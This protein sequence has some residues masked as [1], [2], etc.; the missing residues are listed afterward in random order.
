[1]QVV[2]NLPDA[3]ITED[4]IRAAKWEDGSLFDMILRGAMRDAIIL[5]KGHGAIKDFDKI[6]W[7][8]CIT[9]FDCPFRHIDCKDCERAECDRTQVDKIPTIIEADEAESEET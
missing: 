1:M 8:G 9:E 5:P 3:N 7:Y 6:E 4:I 2:I